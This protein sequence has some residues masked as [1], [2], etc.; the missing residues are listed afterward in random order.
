ME[1]SLSKV[2]LE[3]IVNGMNC[4]SNANLKVVENEDGIFIINEKD[5][6]DIKN[7]LHLRIEDDGNGLKISLSNYNTQ[8]EDEYQELFDKSLLFTSKV[9]N[10]VF[11]FVISDD[12]LCTSVSML[13]D[14][15]C[16]FIKMS[17]TEK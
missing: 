3:H 11:E 10:K 16:R 8:F 2:C 14:V 7:K 5:S 4:S 1:S 9:V 6:S 15:I 17:V 12:K 13:T